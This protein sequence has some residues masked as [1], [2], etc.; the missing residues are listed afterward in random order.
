MEL[1]HL[2]YFVAVA[3]E[4]HF[5]RAAERLHIAQPAV[6][7]QIRKLEAE[8]GVRLLERTQR[9]VALTPAGAAML[10]EARRV[11]HQADV[12]GRAARNAKAHSLG[13]LRIGYL[14][15]ALPRY[16]PRA[17]ARMTVAAPGIDILLES[18]PPLR[19]AEDVREGRLDSAVI[20]LPAPVGDL[21]LTGLGEETAVC[22]VPESHRFASQ[23]SVAPEEIAGSPMV[24]LPRVLN[25]AFYDAVISSWR[26]AGV[27][28]DPI[29]S[30]EPHVGHVLLSVA[31]GAG[32]GVL[33]A[34]VAER[35]S[36]PG[37]R[38]APLDPSP[39]CEVAIVTRH[40][41]STTV[42]ALLRLAQ[43]LA[44]SAERTRVRALR[45]S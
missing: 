1:R 39:A 20:C 23:E 29:E 19:L 12:A 45:A 36:I 44:R 37:V 5:R 33:P 25:P 34:S 41:V 7:E 40:E 18:G 28:A 17:L 2:R 16:V 27:V 10:E 13:R 42:A 14:A 22:A 6:S 24:M 9:S 15:D 35:H 4:L 31:A 32:I 21:R 26:G 11:L 43:H 8:L 38:F 3:E 30:N